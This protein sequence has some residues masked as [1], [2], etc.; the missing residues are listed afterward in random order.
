M[1]IAIVYSFL[2]LLLLLV[3]T[4]ESASSPPAVCILGSGIGGSSV[5]HFLRTYSSPSQVGSIRMFER[6]GVV[7]GRMATVTVS[8]E[9]FEAGGSILHPKN[10]HALNFT[11]YLNLK[12]K[13]ASSSESDSSFGIWDGSKFVFKTLPLNPKLSILQKFVSFANSVLIFL[14][15][16]FSL[17]RMENFVEGTVDKFLKFY[18]GFESRPVFEDVEDMLRWS[19]LYNLT[20]RT[21]EEELTDAGL[22]TTLI[23]ELVTVITRINYGQSVTMSGLAGAVSL[24]G[25]GGGLWSVEGGNWQMAAGLINRS[26]VELHLGED[27]DSV[28]YSGKRYELKTTKGKSYFCEVV[29]VATPLDELNINFLPG[30]T[31]PDRKLQHTHTTFIRGL[32]NP[33]Y[34]GL[35]SLSDLPELVGTIETSEVPFSSISVLKRYSEHDMTYKLFSRSYMEDDLLEKIFSVRNKTIKIDWGAYPVFHAP[36]VFAPL[37]LDSQHLY[38]V[39]AFENAASTMETSAV[40]AENIVRL[41]LSRLEIEALSSVPGSSSDALKMHS[42]L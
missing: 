31:I 4:S 33:S 32:L 30:I 3:F 23:Q 22:S 10:Y 19:G 2:F 29:V 26:N 24:A 35:R 27:I 39:N 36:E 12:V 34:F 7:G 11:N 38:Y 15:Y 9:S 28:Y 16:G 14:R 13:R 20:R 5:A 25:S 6:H 40:S 42:E 41:I 37:I 17:F 8:G 21:L 1:K 18:E